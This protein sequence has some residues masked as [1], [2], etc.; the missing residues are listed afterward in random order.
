MYR[1]PVIREPATWVIDHSLSHNSEIGESQ[2][3]AWQIAK[4]ALS[5]QDL[6]AIPL[7]LGG[8][9]SR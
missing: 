7:K 6:K 8:L 1:T 2:K 5:A 3:Q 4:T 9:R